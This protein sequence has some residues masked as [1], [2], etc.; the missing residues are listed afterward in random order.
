MI[1]ILYSIIIPVYNVEKYLH[2]CLD[3]VINQ[4]YTKLEIILVNDGSKDNSGIICDKYAESDSRIRVIHQKN[5]GVSSARNAGLNIATGDYISFIDPDDYIELNMYEQLSLHLSEHAVDIVRFGALR[6][7]DVLNW[8]P[9]E[10]FYEG[11]DFEKEILLPMIGSEKFGGM[12]ILGVLWMHVFKRDL[13]EKHNIRFNKKLRRCE[14]RLFTISCMMFSSGELFLRDTLYHY[15]I[16][17]ESLSNKY[18][19]DRWEQ[20]NLY[21]ENLKNLYTKNKN[22]TFV[23]LA[24]GRQANDYILRVITSINQEYFSNNR[25]SFW[26]RYKNI[27]TIICSD[28]TKIALSE[29]ESA[30]MGLKGTIMLFLIKK[31]FVFLLNSFNTFIL[32]KNKL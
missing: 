8:L 24:N 16:N 31:R 30:K 32:L 15:I 21:L 14:D 12:F 7:G 10:G 25:N 5:Q 9:F 26:T 18:D 2:R 29:M 6:N 27:K 11:E 20:E 28:T 3:S 17:D 22:T 1:Q 23:E 19:S 4:T 13:I